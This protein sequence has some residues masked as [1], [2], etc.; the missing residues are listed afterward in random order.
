MGN[1]EAD[2]AQH[3]HEQHQGETPGMGFSAGPPALCSERL[4]FRLSLSRRRRGRP[5]AWAP[6][7]GPAPFVDRSAFAL[8]A[9]GSRFVRGNGAADSLLLLLRAPPDRNCWTRPGPVQ[10]VRVGRQFHILDFAVAARSIGLGLPHLGGKHAP[11]QKHAEQHAKYQPDDSGYD[12]ALYFRH[13]VHRGLPFCH[14]GLGK[15]PLTVVYCITMRLFFSKSASQELELG[16]GWVRIRLLASH[17]RCLGAR[18]GISTPSSRMMTGPRCARQT[19]PA[20]R[21]PA[22]RQRHAGLQRIGRQPA[23]PGFSWTASPTPWPSPV[24][25][26]CRHSRRGDQV[27]ATASGLHPA[28][29]A[30]WQLRPPAEPATQCRT[31]QV[32]VARLAQ[33]HRPR[34][35]RT[36]AVDHIARSN[37]IGSPAWITRSP[38]ERG[39]AH[40]SAQ[41]HDQV[42][43][44]LAGAVGAH[45]AL[46]QPCHLKLGHA[47]PDRLQGIGQRLVGERHERRIVS[48][49]ASSLNMRTD[50][51]RVLDGTH[52]TPLVAC[53]PGG[54]LVD[55]HV[56][57]LK[58]RRR[59]AASAAGRAASF[60]KLSV[61]RA[62]SQPGASGPTAHSSGNRWP[63]PPG[64][65]HQQLAGRAGKAGEVGRFSG[66]LTEAHQRSAPPALRSFV[67]R[68]G[69][70][71]RSG[72]LRVVRIRQ[73]SIARA[74]IPSKPQQIDRPESAYGSSTSWC[75]PLAN[76]AILSS[77][78]I[79]RLSKWWISNSP[80][81]WRTT[82]STQDLSICSR[83]TVVGER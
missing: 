77:V 7:P 9:G 40:R 23:C 57:A 38:G 71:S 27:A 35:V 33:A 28:I 10:C 53:R 69:F 25:E 62:S 42:N 80:G 19:H 67:S 36:V 81:Q 60:W 18:P 64:C 21:C 75:A 51:D 46:D 13:L 22:D 43:G 20:G 14:V 34:Q 79:S 11:K 2:R 54:K 16:A 66:W 3:E 30:G 39:A 61:I 74:T 1:A 4:R 26:T 72:M 12:S 6:P 63:A 65:R 76:T 78:A 49:S 50:L 37:T 41:T 29:P 58:P 59:H 17:R 5:A 82:P 56:L 32:L 47:R 48:I 45:I 83:I 73:V 70:S 8:V 31:R 55:R 52:S 44:H 24:A 68:I 15:T